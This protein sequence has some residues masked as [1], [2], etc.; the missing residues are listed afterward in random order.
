MAQTL[1][2][3][4][5]YRDA[6][7]GIFISA[8][9]LSLSLYLISVSRVQRLRDVVLSMRDNLV[10]E[11]VQSLRFVRRAFGRRGTCIQPLSRGQIESGADL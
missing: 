3:A 6:L 7:E 8:I 1:E 10:L 9:S 2:E 4:G 5:A 11:P